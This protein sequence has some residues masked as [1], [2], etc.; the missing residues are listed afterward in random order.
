MGNVYGAGLAT[1]LG[2]AG[3]GLYDSFKKPKTGLKS[4]TKKLASKVVRRS[5][6]R[7]DDSTRRNIRAEE[8]R[9]P[10]AA[11]Q[12]FDKY[13]K[14]LEFFKKTLPKIAKT[15]GT[16]GTIAN[17]MKPKPAGAGSD[18]TPEQIKA[19]LDKKK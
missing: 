7:M 4:P 12:R 17:I 13:Q 6:N 9:F 10:G 14:D 5:L 3:F 16:V 1:M 11:Q 19:M 8:R 15:M 18:F 2:V